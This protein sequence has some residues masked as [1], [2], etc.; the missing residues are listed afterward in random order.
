MAIID[1]DTQQ[2]V[3]FVRPICV[4][5]DAIDIVAEWF[6]EAAISNVSRDTKKGD[7]AHVR[8]PTKSTSNIVKR[9]EICG[10]VFPKYTMSKITG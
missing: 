10:V 8:P 1:L 9:A 6:P 7:V 4:K 2:V 3:S 5:N